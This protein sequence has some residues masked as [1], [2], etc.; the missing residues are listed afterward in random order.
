MKPLVAAISAFAGIVATVS[1]V[2]FVVRLGERE[3]A[4]P[5]RCSAGFTPSQGRCC[6]AGQKASKARCSGKTATCPAGFHASTSSR[7]GCVIDERRLKYVGGRLSIGND[8]W[9]T[10]GVVQPRTALVA[11]FALDAAEVT[12]ERWEH[13]VRAGACRALGDVEPGLPVTLVDARE[14]ERFCRL[15]SGR[16][17]SGDEWLF[18]AMGAEGRRF[19]WGASGL[20]CR[21]VAFGLLTGPCATAGGAELAGARPDGATADGAFDLVGNVAEWTTERDGTHVA[22]GGSFE[23]VA[24]VELKSWSFEAAEKPSRHIGFRCAYDLTAVSSNAP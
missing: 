9:Q 18:A 24:A 15:D 3:R 12:G 2:V 11:P 21:R 10:E 6:P 13:C 14:A 16:L 23:S 19:P 8:D 7:R 5:A 17:P 22:R 1:A 4:D 20:V